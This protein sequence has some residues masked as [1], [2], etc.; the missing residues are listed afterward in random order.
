MIRQLRLVPPE[1][2]RKNRDFAAGI[3]KRR[4]ARDQQTA[5]FN[6]SGICSGGLFTH[7]RALPIIAPPVQRHACERENDR[8]GMVAEPSPD[9]LS[10]IVRALDA[11]LLLIR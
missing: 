9:L 3:D 1:S 7:M 5:G 8:G 11:P 4:G 10:H 2:L 6:G